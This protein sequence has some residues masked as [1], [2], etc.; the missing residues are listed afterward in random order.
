MAVSS[1]LGHCGPWRMTAESGEQ[2]VQDTDRGT[3]GQSQVGILSCF[4]PLECS[5]PVMG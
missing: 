5:V 4:V 2:F 3:G 1:A